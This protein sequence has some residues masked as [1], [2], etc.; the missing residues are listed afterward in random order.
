MEFSR[1][2]SQTMEKYRRDTM[3]KPLKTAVIGMGTMG[4]KYAAFLLNGQVPA[5]ELAAVTRVRPERLKAMNLTLPDDL[6]VFPSADALFQALD[7]GRLSLD[8]VIIVTPHRL[9]EEQTLAA[10]KRGLHVLCDKPAGISSRQARSAEEFCPAELTYAFIFQQRTFPVYKKIRELVQ[11][12][13]YGSLKRVSWTVTDWYRPNLY[14]QEVSWRGTWLLDGGG[15]L[16]NQC[17]HNLDLLQWICGVPSRVQGFC[18]NGK[19][20]PIEVEDEVTAYME[21]DNGAS[22][23]FTASTGE[24]PGVN[25]LEISLDNG[26][27][28]Y[29]NGEL[30]VCCLDKPE[31]EYRLHAED[32]FVKPKSTWETIPLETNQQPYLEILDNFAAAVQE[33]SPLIAPGEEGRKSLLLSNA[34][35]LSSWTGKMISIPKEGSEDEKIF[36]EEFEKEWR[37]R[38]GA[39]EN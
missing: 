30:K 26:L 36:E 9:H 3:M 29:E 34:V 2:R 4:S 11:S 25:R 33:G 35:Y 18:H 14:Y 22:G 5:M 24:A 28:I 8:A 10:M 17:P 13:K 31:L 20:H 7:E 27:I 23:V 16:L 1:I 38:A 39:A 6:P 15:T 32:A 19:Y 21:W 37:E 12:G